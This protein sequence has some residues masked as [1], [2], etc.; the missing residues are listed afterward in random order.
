MTNKFQLLCAACA[1]LSATL[2]LAAQAQTNNVPTITIGNDGLMRWSDTKQEAAFYGVNYTAPFAHAYRALGYLGL[3]R[4]QA[5]DRDVYHFAR[6]GFNAYRVHIWDVEITDSIGNIIANEHL[7]LLDY[8]LA[9]LQERGIRIVLTTQMHFGNGYP[10]PNQNTGGYSQ[11]FDKCRLHSDPA[12]IAAQ[13]RYVGQLVQHLNPYTQRSYKDEPYIVGIEIN[14]EPCHAESPAQ[15]EAYIGAM[16]KAMRQAGCT[17][18]AFYNVSHNG[19]H[20]QAY[21]NAAV[22]GATYQWYPI[23]L[24]AGFTRQGNFL[25]YVDSYATPFDA[26]KGA[27]SKSKI[28]YEFDAAD[29]LYS[30]LYPAMA[31]AFRSAG[32]QWITQFAYDPIDLAW[33]N[34]EYQTHFLN[35]AYTPHKALSMKI[36]AEAARLLPRNQSYGKYP[37]DTL[38]G[39]FRVSYASDLSE[40]NCADKFFYS[41]TTTTLPQSPE[42]LSAVAGC[43]SSPAVEYEGTGAYFLDKIE[44]GI[45]RLEVMPDA[46]QLR[47]PFNK[48]S[49]KKEVVTIAWNE[50]PMTIKLPNLGEGFSAQKLSGTLAGAAMQSATQQAAQQKIAVLPGVYLLAKNGLQPAAKW[51]AGTKWSNIT[52]G[53]F[54]APQARAKNFAVWHQPNAVAV[55]GRSLSLSAQVVGSDFPD[56]VI[57]YSDRISFWAR[58]NPHVKMERTKGYTYHAQVPPEMLLGKAFRY[59]I[60]VCKGDQK[61]TA[62]A[63]VEG[64]PLDWDYTSSDY[65]QTPVA[66]AGSPL[67][68]FDAADAAPQNALQTHSIPAGSWAIAQPAERRYDEAPA[69][70]YTL[71]AS[72]PGTRFYFRKPITPLA[73]ARRDLLAGAT[74]I[75]IYLK[76]VDGIGALKAGFVCAN[77]FTYTAAL[78]LD[79]KRGVYK[80]PIAALV[81]DSTALLP[82]PYPTFLSLYFVP[83]R[84]IPLDIFSIETLEISTLG[85]LA[86]KA[87]VEIGSVWI[88]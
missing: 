35:L 79:Q 60:V 16:L 38:F 57:V 56:S 68:L 34:T 75:G 88:E 7:D 50:W 47:D 44:D 27:A 19:S 69:V 58:H 81:Q 77:G 63:G 51:S 45:W 62:P 76:N 84:Q 43:G 17:K 54:V 59:T 86:E 49:L 85:K 83:D 37:A 2:T 42:K 32:F 5:I 64:S 13:Q 14:N 70:K 73:I 3:D 11:R 26:L 23:G 21:F 25:P 74:H 30:H 22:Q 31:R 66:Q 78:T 8:L 33:A 9:K 48:A 67:T 10:E 65:Y 24:V 20:V 18:P 39:D 53:E 55:S 87:E 1:L 52:L 71:N 46:I 6:L 15:T 61:I 4:K 82:T 36:A 40:L 29:V 41:N 28:V 80:L 12:A 72:K